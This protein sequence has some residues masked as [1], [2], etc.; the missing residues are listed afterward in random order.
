MPSEV[1]NKPRNVLLPANDIR[2]PITFQF[3][4]SV[5]AL[6][7]SFSVQQTP[8]EIAWPGG[9]L[10]DCGLLL[11]ELLL[12]MA[13]IEK[14]SVVTVLEGE[15]ES[16]NPKKK[17]QTTSTTELSTRLKTWLS[18]SLI[19]NSWSTVETVLLHTPNLQVVELGCGVG[20]TGFVASAALGA[21]TTIL[22]DLQEVVEVVTHDNVL[23]NSEVLNTRDA[24]GSSKRSTK[25][26]NNIQAE[27]PYRILKHFKGGGK[28]L[29]MP[30]CWGNVEQGQAV[31]D[32]LHY[33]KPKVNETASK[34]STKRKGK[35][36]QSTTS[37]LEAAPPLPLLVADR[38]YPD[39]ILLGDV[40]YQHK[41]GAPSHFDILVETLQQLM[42]PRVATEPPSLLMFGIRLRMPASMDLLMLL[43]EHF[44]P[45]LQEPIPAELLD[46]SLRGVKHNMTIHI[47]QNQTIQ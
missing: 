37:S 25:D 33:L 3:Q 12:A 11:A 20:L 43:Q 32:A 46:Q 7:H 9:A 22:T 24:K 31:L 6:R 10:W 5:G 16:S 14:C 23:Q 1:L 17:T 39:L 47:F 21:A 28:V 42:P 38:K 40:A 35:N 19:T 18:K 27:I 44:V 26:H 34:H 41:P 36:K 29:D 2:E 8:E 15:H 13:G 45:V 30:L 4:H